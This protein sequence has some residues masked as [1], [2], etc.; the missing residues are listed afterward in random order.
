M[1]NDDMETI[2]RE[3]VAY[4]DSVGRTAIDLMTSINCG[5][6]V[7]DIAIEII[8]EITGYPVTD[9]TIDDVVEYMDSDAGDMAND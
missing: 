2:V 8:E 7:A 4:G 6:P 1:T 3:L 9:S 5:D